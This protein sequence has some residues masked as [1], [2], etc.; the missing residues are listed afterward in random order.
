MGQGPSI[1]YSGGAA[2]SEDV[3]AW[4]EAKHLIPEV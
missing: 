3:T 2:L 4:L 1:H